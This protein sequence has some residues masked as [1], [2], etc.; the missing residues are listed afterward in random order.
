MHPFKIEQIK[1]PTEIVMVMDAAQIG[2]QGLVNYPG[3]LSGTWAADADFNFIQN[4]NGIQ[5][6]WFAPGGL[7]QWAENQLPQGV[8]AGLNKDYATYDQMYADTGSNNAEGNDMRFRH[9][10]NTQANALFVDGHVGIIP[11][12]S[13]GN[14]RDRYAIQEL[15]PRRLPHRGFG[16]VV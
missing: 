12:E 5:A 2:N 3:N 15:Y 11:L 10:N 4:D 8:D 14:R 16:A 6:N 13:T 9:M 1:R 7:L